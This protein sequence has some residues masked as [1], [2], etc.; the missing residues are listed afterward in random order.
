MQR[1]D[2]VFA[3]AF[4]IMTAAILFLSYKYYFDEPSVV[5]ARAIRLVD[6]KG[7]QRALLSSATEDGTACIT[8]FDAN[9]RPRTTIGILPDGQPVIVLKDKDGQVTW[10]A[11]KGQ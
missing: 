9:Q 2:V 7:N 5:T 3:A 11:K 6:G 1:R 10:A 8:L 4:A